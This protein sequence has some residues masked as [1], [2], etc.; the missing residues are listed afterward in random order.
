MEKRPG[1]EA[2]VGPTPSTVRMRGG[3]P[4]RH[5]YMERA[6]HVAL[7]GFGLVLKRDCCREKPDRSL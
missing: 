1:D 2:N 5:I 3:V 7:I 6:F 4:L